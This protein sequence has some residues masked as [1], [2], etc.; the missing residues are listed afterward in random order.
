[1]NAGQALYTLSHTPDP[2]YLKNVCLRNPIFLS[3]FQFGMIHSGSHTYGHALYCLLVLGSWGN[4]S[5]FSNGFPRLT[6]LGLK[7]GW[8]WSR[9]TLLKLRP[10]GSPAGPTAHGVSFQ[11]S[12][13]Q[14]QS[15]VA[16]DLRL[17]CKTRLGAS[18]IRIPLNRLLRCLFKFG[19]NLIDCCVEPQE[20]G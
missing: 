19:A 12:W 1:M 5:V 6:P 15:P 4:P 13:M 9:M 18:V 20:R 14:F 11:G 10:T 8:G 17:P 7:C 16:G 2:N 3:P